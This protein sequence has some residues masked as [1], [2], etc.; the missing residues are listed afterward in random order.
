MYLNRSIYL[1]AILFSLA[2]QQGFSQSYAPISIEG[3]INTYTAV[4]SIFCLE[5]NDVDS[6]I[7]SDLTGFNENDTVMLYFVKGAKIVE[8]TATGFFDEFEDIG[9]DS[10]NPGNTGRYAFLIINEIYAPGKV[11]VFNNKITPH[12][13]PMREGEMAQLIRVPSYRNAKVKA[14]GL[15]ADPWDGTKGGV[16]TLFVGVLELNGD[17]DA[18]GM[19]LRGASEDH[20]YLYGCSSENMSVLDSLFYHMDNYSAGKKGEG[21]TDAGFNRLRGRVKNINGGGGGNGLFSGGGGGSNFYGGGMGGYESDQCA[22]GLTD[23]GGQGG[24]SL[25][26]HNYFS[27][28]YND[29]N[30]N[31]NR[32]DRISFGGGG[33]TGTRRPGIFTSDGGNGGGLVVI[34]ADSIIGNDRYIRADGMDADDAEG[35]A[36][37]GGGGGCIV[38]DVNGYRT[39]LN[40]SAR[41]GNG[42][43]TIGAVATGPGGGGGGG[44]Y[45]LS[46]I[47]DEHSELSMVDD[48]GLA[49]KYNFNTPFGATDGT[50]P[51]EKYGLFAPIRGFIFNPVPNEFRVCSDMLPLPLLAAE[52]RGGDGPEEGYTYLWVDSSS[53]QNEWLAAPGGPGVVDQQNYY[54]PGLLSDTTYFRR[55]VT[56]GLLPNDTS[57]RIA[58]YVHPGITNNTISAPDTV[59]SGNAPELFEPSALIGGGPSGPRDFH[60]IWKKDE[61]SGMT[62]VDGDY[63]DSAYQSPGLTATTDFYRIAKSGVCVDTSSALNVKVWEK[64][65]TFQIEDNDTVCYNTELPELLSSQGGVSPGEGDQGDIRYQ[66]I[67]STDAGSWSDIPGATSE[68]YQP[69]AQTQDAYFSRIVLSGSDNA[70]VDTAGY[71]EIL[72]IR[73]IDNNTISETQTV[74]TDDNA[75]TLTGSDPTGGYDDMLFSYSWEAMTKSGGWTAVTDTSF[76]KIDFDPGVMDGDTTWYRRVV[77]AG[78]VNRNVCTDPGNEVV[79]NVLPPIANNLITTS[80]SVLC[81]D[82]F[83]EDLTQNETGGSTPIGGDDSWIYQWQMASGAASPGEYSDIDGAIGRDYLDRPELTGDADRWFRRR[84]YSGPGNVCRDFSIPVHIEVHT[85]ITGNAIDPVDSVCFN[86]S[87]EV[88]GAAPAGEEGLIPAY[89]WRDAQTGA[90]LP[91]PYGQNYSYDIFDIQQVYQFEREVKIGACTDTSNTMLIT[92]MQLPEGILSGDIPR[93]CETDVLL[94]VDLNM[95]GLNTYITPWEIYLD[96]GVNTSLHGP[97]LLNEDGEVEVT[98]HTDSDSTQFTYTPGRIVYRSVTG[99]FECEAPPEQLSGQV[100]IKVFRTPDPVITVDD[101]ARES[102]KV[103]G[104]TIELAA[105]PD[106]GNGVWT[107]APSDYISESPTSG[108]GYAISIPYISEAFGTYKATFTSTA[109][110]CSGSDSIDLYYFEQPEQPDVGGDTL[111]FLINQVEL[112]ATPPNAGT[113]IWTVDPAGPNIEDPNSPVTMARYL[114][115]N[116]E[117]TFRWTVTNGEDEGKCIAMDTFKVITRTEV[118]RYQGFSP[119]G[120]LDNEYF[121]MRGMSYADEFTITF[122]NSLGNTVK[123]V[124]NEDVDELD[125]IPGLIVDLREDELVVWD[126]RSKNG[127]LV[128]SGTYYYAVE[129]IKDGTKYPYEDYVVVLRDD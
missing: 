125:V 98:L 114:G 46:G 86:S 21:N 117:N 65:I 116:V 115:L 127:T 58:V 89:T 76:V 111:L 52:P 53:T 62:T 69:Q 32:Y 104:T 20:D 103:C 19:G 35:A 112:R 118:K 8:D 18:S 91:G 119:N 124:T 70:C 5:E 129:Y 17:I 36:G 6:V 78:G 16:I 33:G 84:V 48:K 101:A 12:I 38:L 30:I 71:V 22:A 106:R 34:V 110:V 88:P 87:K 105:Y 27:N 55:I 51:G 85:G 64:H 1:L 39:L 50:G 77:G 113:G 54:F 11:V 37:G 47:E 97:S 25:N 45:W 67:T 63:T 75:E 44:A 42:G 57:F 99:R 10:L 28:Y 14:S 49:G 23:P 80:D 100:P 123:T 81:E 92:V 61:G 31:S 60:Y 74:C 95:E 120:D 126:G 107:F 122:Y 94:N 13:K 93:S 109:G 26:L 43:N 66:W 121:I 82:D 108:N 79:I 83:L 2:F 41:G 3:V 96:D 59:C 90:D 29:I 102:S 24:F 72:N 128:P 4:E 7:V 56:S 15:T 68:S 40:L 73:L 9:G